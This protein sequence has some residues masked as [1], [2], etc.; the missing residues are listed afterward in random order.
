[1]ML[2]SYL[3]DFSRHTIISKRVDVVATIICCISAGLDIYYIWNDWNNYNGE[4][5]VIKCV[6]GT[7]GTTLVMRGVIEGIHFKGHINE[8]H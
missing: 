3:N 6:I 8:I 2:I 4:H 1:M 7:I 5:H